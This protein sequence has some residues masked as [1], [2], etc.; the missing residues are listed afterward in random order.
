MAID[1]EQM[2][3]DAPEILSSDAGAPTNLVAEPGQGQA[4]E[5]AALKAPFNLAKTIIKP[6]TTPG[7]KTAPDYKVKKKRGAPQPGQPI[8]PPPQATDA[9]EPPIELPTPISE[10]QLDEFTQERLRQVGTP[11]QAPSPTQ[12]QK[13][14]GIEQGRANTQFYD[15]DELAATVQ[16]FSATVGKDVKAQT[17]QSIYDRAKESG[18]P[19][20]ILENMFR[21]LPLESKV[22]ANQLAVKLAGLQELHDASAARVDEMMVRAASGALSDVEKLQLREAIA[23]HMIIFDQMTGAKTDVARA[24]NVFKGVREADGVSQAQLRAALDNLGGDDQLRALAES[25]VKVNSRNGRNKLLDA[26]IGKKTLDAIVY[27]N[28][29]VLLTNWDTHL[30]NFAANAATLIMDVPERALAMPVGMVRQG[31]GKAVNSLSQKIGRSGISI[32]PDRYYAQDIY[33][34]TSAF[35]NGILDGLSL[36]AIRLKEGGAAK[37]AAKN[38]ISAEAFSNTKF[39]MLSAMVGKEIRTGDLSGTLAGKSLDALGLL[40]SIVFR[41]LSAGDAFTGGIAARMELHEQAWRYG[42]GIYDAAIANGKTPDQALATAQKEVGTFLTERPADIEAS[43]DA[44]RKQATLTAMI[45]M[46]AP[47]GKTYW[48]A[49]KVMNH[50]AVKPITLFSKTV[51]NIGIEGA[52]RIPILNFVSPRFYSE[53]SKGGRHRDLAISRLVLGGT[54]GL[55]GY[56]LAANGKTTGAGPS[57][58]EDRK[59]LQSAGWQEFSLVFGEDEL[60]PSNVSKLQQMLGEDAVTVGTGNLKGKVYVSLKRLDPVNMPFLMGAALADAMKFQEYD[61][62]NTEISTMVDAMAA[63]LAEY[64]TSVPTMQGIAEFASIFGQRQTDKGDR[65]A[66]MIDAYL[67]RTASFYTTR[68]TP[69]ANFADSALLGKIESIIDPRS[70]NVAPTSGQKKWAEDVLGMDATKPGV[71]AFFEAYNRMLSKIPAFNKGVPVKLDPY[72]N[73]VGSDRMLVATPLRVS[74]GHYSPLQMLLAQINHGVSYPSFNIDGV[75][76]TA[77]QQNRYIKLYAKEIKIDGMNMEA[78][79]V[80][81]LNRAIDDYSESGLTPKIGVLQNEVNEVVDQYRELARLRMFGKIYRLEDGEYEMVRNP[82]TGEPEPMPGAMYGLKDD[83][84]EFP[85][86]TRDMVMNKNVVVRYGK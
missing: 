37:D 81:R 68:A 6:L 58:T 75:R 47:L 41:G 34:R 32:S 61:P 23:Q 76:L 1:T 20:R 80:D 4:I 65:M 79:I 29:S 24:M 64:S 56:Q 52:A 7:A 70:S 82:A 14:A 46:E 30:Y 19:E 85:S 22:G 13:Q 10:Q 39:K 69:I 8:E 55:A 31:V 28:Q 9:T 49:I 36:A 15:A 40:Y 66:L 45:D 48:A 84:V 78:A 67:R 57:D 3:E 5:V 77:D 43:V 25:Y 33:A 17:V 54:V 44:F 2:P 59:A 27:M 11:R 73:E 50:W 83:K 74:Q 38:P 42:A 12:K 60:S 63:S 53:F 16:A 72:G 26:G 21:G 86:L 51:T 71:R 35:Y 18:V 62:D